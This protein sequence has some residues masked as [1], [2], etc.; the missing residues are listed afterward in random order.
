MAISA[1]QLYISSRAD[2]GDCCIAALA[3]AAG[4]EYTFTFDKE[5]AK[6][7]GMRLLA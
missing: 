7:P 2:F 4:C 5:A 1:L 6:L 3:A